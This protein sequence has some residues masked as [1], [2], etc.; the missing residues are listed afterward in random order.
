MMHKL[1]IKNFMALRDVEIE[2][3]K[4]LVLIGEQASGKSTIAKLIYFFK[5]LREDLLESVYDDSDSLHNLWFWLGDNIAPKF[6]DFFGSIRDLSE[7]E[8]QYFY[9]DRKGITLSSGSDGALRL[10]LE[11]ELDNAISSKELKSLME[12]MKQLSARRDTFELLALRRSV[13]DFENLT[14]NAFEDDRRPLFI[15]AGR[16]ITVNYPEQFKL[17]FYGNLRSLGTTQDRDGKH[18]HSADLYLMVK[19]LEQVER[20]KDRFKA[21]DFSGF[22]ADKLSKGEKVNKG[23]IELAQVKIN[24]ILKGEYRQDQNTEKIF[25]DDENYVHLNNASSGQQEAI[26]IL[27]DLFLTL[28]DEENVF[29][30]IEEPEAHLYPMAQK[31][32]IEMIAMVL[33]HSDSQ[34]VITTHS[35]YILSIFNNLLFATRVIRK[36]GAAREEVRQVIP[37]AC[38]LDPEGCNV[39][40][41]KDGVCKSIFD[42]QT[43]LIGQNHLDDIS[44]ALGADFDDLYE[45]HGRSFK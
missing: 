10:A 33:N 43:G 26:R 37:E 14:N 44:E 1:R 4:V 39:Y 11:P 15:S 29:R 36:N 28:L 20:I 13:V 16:S 35:P 19:F 18:P 41:L 31:H 45:I 17:D 7:F 12:N 5:S 25:Y 23:L 6:H 38:W 42:S 21:H 2:L 32:L 24:E 30:V 22:L 3:N 34:F 27:Q 9:S 40:L 8:I